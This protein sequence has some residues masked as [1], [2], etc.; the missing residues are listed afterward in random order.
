MVWSGKILAPVAFP[1]LP[2]RPPAKH[3]S[4]HAVLVPIAVLVVGLQLVNVDCTCCYAA[5]DGAVLDL[6]LLLLW[7]GS[8]AG[9]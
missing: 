4:H 2:K 5:V 7:N 9:L 8:V 1:H 6:C 3:Y